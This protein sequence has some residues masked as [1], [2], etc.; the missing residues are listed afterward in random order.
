MTAKLLTSQKLEMLI[1]FI[2]SLST[3]TQNE[4]KQQNSQL[5]VIDGSILEGGG[6]ILRNA[7]ALS[8]LFKK[9][10]HIHNIR[11]K[12]QVPG[13]RKQHSKGIE[14]IKQI[15]GG[16]LEGNYVKSMEIK[17]YPN[18]YPKYMNKY[19]V[20]IETAGSICLLIQTSLPLLL[21]SPIPCSL[22]IIGGTNAC[23][24][25]QIDYFILLLKPMLK[26]LMNIQ[27]DIH[28]TQRGFVPKGGGT[29]II[30]TQPIKKCIPAFNLINRGEMKC[31]Y[32]NVIVAGNLSLCIADKIINGAMN[33]LRTIFDENISIK[34][35]IISKDETNSTSSGVGIVI[36]GETNSQCLFGGSALG[37]KNF[38]K[39][40]NKRKYNE[41]DQNIYYENIGKN[42]AR[43]LIN[44]WNKTIEGCT[45]KWLQDQLIIFMA[46][47]DGVSK[48]KTCNLELHT[49]TAIYIAQLLTGAKFNVSHLKNNTVLIECHGIGYKSIV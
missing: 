14:L 42:A 30:N 11:G 20:N 33:E 1:Q 29:V 47:A 18:N 9:P 24:S 37:N 48:M 31:I 43:E 40:K 16:I 15:N 46:L 35:D 10:I 49:E 13:L 32:G 44:D 28:C 22:T 27:M 4:E 5:I 12:R 36:I 39:K 21:F 2:Q 19:S 17:F 6:Q 34:L 25:P 41:N 8:A 45:D 3:S 23:F 7:T 38:N 26:R